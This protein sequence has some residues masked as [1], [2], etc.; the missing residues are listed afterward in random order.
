MTR[1]R[2]TEPAELAANLVRFFRRERGRFAGGKVHERL[3]ISGRIVPLHGELHHHSFRDATDHW[4]RCQKYARLWAETQ[5]E[6]RQTAGPLAPWLHASFRWL[7]A[8]ILRRGFLDGPQ[9]W[10][11]AC[12]S[13]REVALKY[14]LLRDLNRTGTVR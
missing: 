7:R 6:A 11:I 3:E 2:V 13:A 14:R 10:R 12:L 9:G 8:Y 1:D 4:A 5:H